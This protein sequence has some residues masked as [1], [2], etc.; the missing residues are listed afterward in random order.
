MEGVLVFCLRGH[1]DEVPSWGQAGI[2]VGKVLARHPGTSPAL[3][4]LWAEG[5]PTGVPARLSD[6][7][8]LS[9]LLAVELQQV[10]K[11]HPKMLV[12]IIEP[13]VPGTL[14][15]VGWDAAEGGSAWA[16]GN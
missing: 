7:V 10:A 1:P 16:S 9:P 12:W 2:E 3:C 14:W 8:A 13:R 15:S 5:R 11:R 6:G 4:M